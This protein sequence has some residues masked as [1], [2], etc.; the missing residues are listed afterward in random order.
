MIRRERKRMTIMMLPVNLSI[1]LG[2]KVERKINKL[3]HRLSYIRNGEFRH[4]GVDT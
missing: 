1:K 3:V 2:R 4:E